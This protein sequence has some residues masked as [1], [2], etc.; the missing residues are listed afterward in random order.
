[1]GHHA[2]CGLALGADRWGTLLPRGLAGAAQ[3]LESTGLKPGLLCVNAYRSI[4]KWPRFRPLPSSNLTGRTERKQ[5]HE[6]AI[7][8][9]QVHFER[10]KVAP[11]AFFWRQPDPLF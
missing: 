4:S 8:D 6:A 2:L 11:R 9:Q 5:P 10:C 3:R 1:M 7:L